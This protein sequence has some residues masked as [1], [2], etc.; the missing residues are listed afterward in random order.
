MHPYLAISTLYQSLSPH[1]YH[2]P[3]MAI[4]QQFFVIY[5]AFPLKPSA[6]SQTNSP[7]YS[8]QKPY[9]HRFLITSFS[10]FAITAK[11]STY[12][13][14]HGHMQFH[15]FQSFSHFPD[16]STV[17]QHCNKTRFKDNH[18]LNTSLK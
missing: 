12:S 9:T 11:S 5:Y 7:F 3:H 10:P 6:W 1:V 8:F 14:S 16:P 2:K 13:S 4:C 17:H 15:H 18:G